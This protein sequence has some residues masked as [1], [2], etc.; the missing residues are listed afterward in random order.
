MRVRDEN[1]EKE[2]RT[3]AVQIIVEKG[4]DGL[5]MQKLAK[6]AGVSPATIYIYFKDREDL[7]ERISIDEV[8][9]MTQVTLKGFKPD[10]SFEK[11]LKKQWENRLAYWLSNP[12]SAKFMEQM[13]HS[14]VGVKVHEKVKQD[15]SLIM[16]EFVSNAIKRKEL[17][18]L[19]IEVYWSVA[20]AP[21]Y[22]LIKFHL[23]GRS[24][25]KKPFALDRKTFNSAFKT[26]L[27]A[28][29]PP[30]K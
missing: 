22:N 21:L 9:R 1:K 29:T 16:H 26:V 23:D 20:Y 2:I 17:I 4:F 14:P 8:E 11:G 25:G 5:S 12:V 27:K 10:M 19:S 28:L 15:F 24:L 18:P 13:K 30:K 6:A 3:K 7:I